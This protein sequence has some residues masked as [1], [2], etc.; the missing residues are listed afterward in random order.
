MI[1]MLV[2]WHDMQ[3]SPSVRIRLLDDSIEARNHFTN[4]YLVN[5]AGAHLEA[6]DT[7]GNEDYVVLPDGKRAM[8][9]YFLASEML[10]LTLFEL[11]AFVLW[12]RGWSLGLAFIVSLGL[13]VLLVFP[14]GHSPS[15]YEEGVAFV[16]TH[17]VVTVLAL[18]LFYL[19]SQLYCGWRFVR[20]EIMA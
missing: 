16:A 20:T 4:F 9:D 15:R 6:P 2:H 12:P 3:S 14:S 17:P 7:G 18:L 13:M 1:P 11:L 10:L 5:F 19:V 8:A